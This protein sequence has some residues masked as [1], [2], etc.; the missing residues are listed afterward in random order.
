V[1]VA[2]RTNAQLRPNRRSLCLRE[3]RHQGKRR[4][5]LAD[6]GLFSAVITQ[7][8]RL[9]ADLSLEGELNALWTTPTHAHAALKSKTQ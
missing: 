8:S 9:T 4:R 1:R 2:G 3:G 6:S 7:G 5:G